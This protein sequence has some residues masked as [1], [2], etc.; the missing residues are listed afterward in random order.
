[1]TQLHYEIN[2]TIGGVTINDV[3]YC[4]FIRAPM[5]K[6]AGFCLLE[7][8]TSQLI[9]RKAQS[10]ISRNVL[11]NITLS[12]YSCDELTDRKVELI[13]TKTFT[14]INISVNRM[15]RFEEDRIHATYLL[16]HPILYYISNNNTLL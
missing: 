6:Q 5:I 15:I 13:F 10:D 11:P 14:C 1:M 8:F 3:T 16:V 7:G 2:F 12:I 9:V 4:S